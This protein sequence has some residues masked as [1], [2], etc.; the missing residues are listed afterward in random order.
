M[1]R[2][3]ALVLLVATGALVTRYGDGTRQGFALAFGFALIAA[4]LAGDLVGRI[5]LPRLTG[6]LIFGALCGPYIANII[7]AAMA[8][9]LQFVNGLAISLI[10]FVA[11][12]E[13]N[14]RHLRPQ[15]AGIVRFG[16]VLMGTMIAGLLLIAWAAWPW[17]PIVPEATGL[18]RI[19]FAALLATLLASFS[20]TVTLA[21]IADCRARGPLSELSLAVVVL[22]DLAIIL[23]FTLAMQLV[24]TVTGGAGEDGA[25]LVS[26][27]LWE[28]VGS[29]AFGAMVG[30]LFGL[31][32]RFVGRELTLMLLALCLV[33]SAL[34]RALHVEAVLSALAAG[35]VVENVSRAGSEALRDAVE[36]GALPVLVVFFAAAGASLRLDVLLSIGGIVVAL[37][38]ARAGLVW[39]AGRAASRATPLAG[40][41]G[42]R[43]WM[44][45][46][47]QAG[48]TLGL[49]TIVASEF[50]GWGGTMQTLVVGLIGLNELAGP[51]LFKRA[52]VTAGEAGRM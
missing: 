49:T 1:R 40:N 52:L 14:Y 22:A 43:V 15:L 41:A 19:A 18:Q 39:S 47:A 26:R 29:L 32:L 33:L 36:R 25:G 46:I 50:A 45:L 24:R 13:L 23:F 2:G 51:I 38:L 21:V 44:A 5:G 31:Y 34:G 8:R 30:S 10:A 11:G 28:V 16:G 48:V 20:P 27:L 35:L 17:L 3:L 37:A 12:L 4:A 6:Y 9:E 42:G 7:S